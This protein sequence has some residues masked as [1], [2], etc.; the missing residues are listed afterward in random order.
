MVRLEG[1]EGEDEVLRAKY[2]KIAVDAINSA[3]DPNP[4][5]FMNSFKSK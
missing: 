1:L 2:S 5:D 3:T 4:P